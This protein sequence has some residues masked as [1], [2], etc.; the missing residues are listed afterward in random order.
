[1][2][3]AEVALHVQIESDIVS[4][5]NTLD[6]LTHLL[7]IHIHVT[8][9]QEVVVWGV[10]IYFNSSVTSYPFAAATHH[11]MHPI[12]LCAARVGHKPTR[13]QLS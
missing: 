5:I 1:M 11:Q 12:L 6:P 13:S 10:H 3:A 8:E 9:F 7:H 2:T 4:N